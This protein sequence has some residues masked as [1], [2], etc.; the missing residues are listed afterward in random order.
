MSAH[1]VQL[2]ADLDA[3]VRAQVETGAYASADEVILAGVRRFKVQTEQEA[4]RRARFLEA[5]QVGLDQIERG[6]V[7]EVTDI[8]TLLTEIEAEVEAGFADRVA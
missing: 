5:V 7:V 4:L 2:P 1:D 6:E 8:R 3:F